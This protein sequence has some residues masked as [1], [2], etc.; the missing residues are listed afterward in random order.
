MLE[1][2]GN[3]KA[4]F[5]VTKL[6]AFEV[7]VLSTVTETKL[8]DQATDQ[9]T[10]QATGLVERFDL[11]QLEH[12]NRDEA[13]MILGLLVKGQLSKRELF[14]ALGV[15]LQYNNFKSKLGPLLLAGLIVPTIKDKPNSP[16][17]KY[18]ITESGRTFLN[19]LKSPK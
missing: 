10:N 7:K 14:N 6:T 8:V 18:E 16:N 11:T 1:E 4:V 19:Y 2:N 15:S 12:I 13:F 9:A 5:D 3:P 17:Q